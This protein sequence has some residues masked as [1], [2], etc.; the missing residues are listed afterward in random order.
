MLGGNG[1]LLLLRGAVER[2][3][4]TRQPELTPELAPELTPGN[5]LQ[6]PTALDIDA[7]APDVV[8][9]S[10]ALSKSLASFADAA[11]QNDEPLV[12][13]VPLEPP[14]SF[15]LLRI[16]AAADYVAA[17]RSLMLPDRVPPVLVD[18]ILDPFLFNVLPR[19]LAPTVAVV[20]VV[21]A[22]SAALSRR[23]VRRLR[24]VAA[25]GASRPHPRATAAVWQAKTKQT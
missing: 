11:S 21:A 4:R 24:S 17:N 8:L 18:L 22:L 3:G 19:S 6:Q 14:T 25:S 15:L 20:L 10:P 1:G 7:F 9:A 16:I 2:L 12:P 13:L 23:I 5:A